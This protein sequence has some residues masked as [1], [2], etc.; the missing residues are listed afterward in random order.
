MSFIQRPNENEK[1]R[2]LSYISRLL[3]EARNNK[4]ERIEDIESLEEIQKLLSQKKYGLI[5]E[6]HAE[7]TEETMKIKI[8][9]FEEKN[10]K[11][12]SDNTDSSTFN[13]LLEGDNLH[14]LHL[15][16]KTHTD[17]IDIIYIDPPYNT[18][19]KDFSY[20]DDFVDSL[21]EFKHSKWLSFMERRL[22]I[23]NRLLKK[24]GIIFISIGD[25]EVAQL[26]LLCDEIFG[27]NAF[28][29]N[30]MV[31]I[32]STTGMKVGTAQKGGIVK[33]GEYILVYS[34]SDLVSTNR[35]PLYDFVPGFDTHFSLF[36]S[37]DGSISKTVDEIRSIPTLVDEINRLKSD[38]EKVTLKTFSKYLNQSSVLTDFVIEN[39]HKFVRLRTEVPAIPYTTISSLEEGKWIKW[40]SLKRKEPYYLTL[41]NGKPANL[42]SMQSTYHYTD[43]F[44]PVY[45]RSI[46]R[47]DYWK[48]FWIDMGNIGKEGGVS[49]KNGKK[50]VRLIKQLLKWSNRPEGIVLDFFAGSG[51][52]GD[53]VSQMNDE[54][55]NYNQKFILATNDEVIDI[56][57]KRM[58]NISENIP[59]NLKYFNTD[60]IDKNA[61][62]LENSLLNNVKTLIELKHGIDLN[63]SSIAIVTKRRDM[64][65][66]DLDNLSSIY[67]RSQTHKML[68]RNQLEKLKDIKII[69][70]PET[71][72]PLEMKEAGL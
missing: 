8:P 22:K 1:E 60:F 13:F 64:D 42:A 56:T 19:N 25:E 6:Q 10:N 58:K 15:L 7:K 65:E 41:H 11:K 16:E 40:K 32:S 49:F 37:D 66:L 48:E 55:A 17:K 20:N 23:A 21:D 24:D 69:D 27:S 62:N 2:A 68:D 50:P 72:F 53:A 67:M 51:T 70:I 14:S 45:G 35:Q 46:I 9:I 63:D 39:V 59:M 31:E 44:K 4:D 18:G 3:D 43:N 36:L 12:I 34:K 28:K 26:K 5:W 47:G 30:I 52:T 57:Y 33:N 29:E 71:F 61:E 54:N 38:S